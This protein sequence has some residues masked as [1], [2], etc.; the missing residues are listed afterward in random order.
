MKRIFV[1]LIALVLLGTAVIAYAAPVSEAVTG[2]DHGWA[3]GAYFGDISQLGYIEEEHFIEGVARPYQMTGELSADGKWTP[4]AGEGVPYKTRILVRYP[5]DSAKFNG[6]VIVEWA[7]MSNKYET[8]YADAQGMYENGFAYVLVT[9]E[10]LGA[11]NLKTWDSA[12]YDSLTIPDDSLSYDIF[13]QAAQAAKGLLGAKKLIAVG[14]SDA[15]SRILAYANGIQPL[16]NTFDALMTVVN[17]GKTFGFG[18]GVEKSFTVVRDD[19]SIPVMVINSQTEA[20]SYADYR[21]SDTDLFRSW[22]IAGAA[23]APDKQTRFLWQKTDRDGITDLDREIAEYRPNEINW[24]YTLNAAFLRVHEWINDGKSPQKFTPIEIKNGEYV[25]NEYGNVLSGV[26]L[27]EIEIPTAQYAAHPNEPLAGY[28][29]RFSEDELKKLYPTHE[30]YVS[31]VSE[32]AKKAED[33][34]IILPYR[35]AEYT[36]AAEVTSVPVM[37]MPDLSNPYLIYFIIGTIVLV[38]VIALLVFVTVKIVKKIRKGRKKRKGN[39]MKQITAL[40]LICVLSLSLVACSGG[41]NNSA[42][43]LP[44]QLVQVMD[45]ATTRGGFE[46]T[47]PVAGGEHGWAFGAYFGDISKLGYIEEEYFIEGVAQHYQ[48]VGELGRDGQWTL[49]AFST[50]PYKTRFIVR[51]PADPAK[52]NGT[53]IMEWANVSAGYDISMMDNQGLF[54]EGFA[55]I[56]V[57]VQVNGLTGFEENPQGLLAWDSERYGSLNIPDDGLSYDIFTQVA[58]AVSKDSPKDG[59]DPMGGLEVKKLFAMGESQ[60]GGRVLSYT[61]G[62]QPIEGL[63]DGIVLIVNAGRG[64]D[65]LDEMAHVKDESGETQLRN[66]ESRVREDINCKVF[67]MNTQTES[68]FLGSLSQPD[69]ANIR[70]LQVAGAAHGAP[71]IVESINQRTDRDGIS[72]IFS[73]LSAYDMTVVDWSYVFEG[74]LIQL[75]NWIDNGTEPPHISEMEAANWILPNVDSVNM[76]MSMVFGYHEDEYKNAKGGVRLPELEVPTARYSVNMLTSGL[77]GYRIPFTEE[78]L[79][80]LYPTHQDYV[81]KV[82]AAARAAEAAGLILPYRAEQYI[83]EA[84]AAPVPRAVVPELSY[85]K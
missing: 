66:V 83:K 35:T 13:T 56:G 27:P 57:S 33:A 41:N 43:I 11:D 81:D 51:R 29:I 49:E 3:Y 61:N 63:F 71:S 31:K 1:M 84:E 76:L 38:L 62:V 79:L 10:K 80:K 9:A 75:E 60:S 26:R 59:V 55:Y 44:N 78:E 20:L 2:G 73:E 77:G 67:I 37:L 42:Q 15:G 64:N 53:V 36:K 7:D 5:E 17:G 85:G 52:F 39:K 16:E 50:A 32:S 4:E 65:F 18:N 14:C 45:G 8:S 24:L 22:E 21:Q 28:T 23:Y 25:L 46:V 69:S 30:D 40:M 19:L 48:P 34:G 68:A 82:T 58:R 72:N 54:D 74:I 70:S 12:R 6:T 47:G